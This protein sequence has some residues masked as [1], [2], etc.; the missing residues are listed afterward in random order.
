MVACLR[1]TLSYQRD[2][3]LNSTDQA[4]YE[5]AAVDGPD[6]RCAEDEPCGQP[7]YARHEQIRLWRI[8]SIP[9]LSDRAAIEG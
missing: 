2:R 1:Y 6:P 9:G 4:F 3:M 7:V 5:I 8:T